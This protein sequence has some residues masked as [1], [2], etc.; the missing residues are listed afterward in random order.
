MGYEVQTK[1]HG[2]ASLGFNVG[3]W[4]SLQHERRRAPDLNVWCIRPQNEHCDHLQKSL[5]LIKTDKTLIS[6]RTQLK[7]PSIGDVTVNKHLINQLQNEQKVDDSKSLV[8]WNTPVKCV[9]KL[10]SHYR[11]FKILTPVS[12]LNLLTLH[13]WKMMLHHTL[14]D[15]Y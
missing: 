2:R 7:H 1:H 15:I 4:N 14:Q 9:L 8:C 13:V 5:S 12:N 11:S 3:K 10:G 6:Q